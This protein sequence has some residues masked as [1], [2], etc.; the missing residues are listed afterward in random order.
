VAPLLKVGHA[1]LYLFEEEQHRLRL[2]G[3]YALRKRNNLDTWCPVGHGLV[4]QVALER[5]PIIFT[6]P[7]ADYI[8]IK[9][10]LGEAVPKTIVVLPMLLNERLVAVL[11]LATFEVFG[12]NEQALLDGLLPILALSIE[13]IER[14]TRTRQLLEETRLQAENMEKQA[15]KLEE[16]AVEMEAQQHEIK[17]TEAW[18]RSIVESAPDGLLVVDEHGSIILTNPQVEAMFGYGS[19]ELLGGPIEILVPQALRDRHLALR[20]TYLT[21]EHAQDMAA[22]NREL[23]GVRKD[24]TEFTV[25]VGLA[26]LPAIGGRGRCVSASVRGSS[27]R[28]VAEV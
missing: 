10:G 24:G 3:G 20:D 12:V 14:N 15:A 23:R 17:A 8:S 19:G 28:N 27:D 2:L 4:G 13:I 11:E 26:R 22:A 16:Q 21:D 6:N 18:F 25:E 1:A 9:S 7:P 5:A